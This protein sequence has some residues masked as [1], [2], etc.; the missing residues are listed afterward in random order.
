[1]EFRSVKCRLHFVSAHPPFD[2]PHSHTH[3]HTHT[4]HARVSHPPEDGGGT[5]LRTLTCTHA[6]T[7]THKNA[8]THISRRRGSFFEEKQHT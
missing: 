6:Y 4:H 8:R 1:M 3:T 7:H 5:Y 2:S